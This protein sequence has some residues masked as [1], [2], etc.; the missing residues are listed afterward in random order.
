MVQ[1]E[2]KF[3]AAASSTRRSF[4]WNVDYVT[5]EQLQ[6]LKFYK[7]S[8]IDKSPL[9]NYIL[10]HYWEFATTLFPRWMAPNLITLT[11]FMFVLLNVGFI[12]I[13]TPDLETQGP[14][15]VYFSFAAGIWLYSTFDNVD[16]KQARRTGTSSPLGELF[17]Q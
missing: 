3:D 15:W 4:F 10:R 9:S 13:Y 2:K 5:D 12:L 11:G 8:S 6:G 7:Y 17:D 1:V 14:G 16:G